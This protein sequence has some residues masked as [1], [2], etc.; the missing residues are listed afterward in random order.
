MVTDLDGLGQQ[1]NFQKIGQNPDFL[2]SNDVNTLNIPSYEQ[3]FEQSL[4]EDP[5]LKIVLTQF[6]EEI[7]SLLKMRYTE[8]Y[9]SPVGESIEAAPVPVV[10]RMVEPVVAVRVEDKPKTYSTSEIRRTL[11]YLFDKVK[12]KPTGKG[13]PGAEK[14]LAKPTPDEI[15][16][17][18]N[19]GTDFDAPKWFVGRIRE[20]RQAFDDAFMRRYHLNHADSIKAVNPILKVLSNSTYTPEQ[21]YA[22]CETYI[23][24]AHESDQEQLQERLQ[25]KFPSIAKEPEQRPITPVL[26]ILRRSPFHIKFDPHMIRATSVLNRV[27]PNVCETELIRLYFINRHIDAWRDGIGKGTQRKNYVTYDE[28]RSFIKEA[29]FYTK[30]SFNRWLHAG[31][32][33]GYWTLASDEKR[34]HYIAFK[35]MPKL[36]MSRLPDELLPD[37]KENQAMGGRMVWADVRGTVQ[38]F[39]GQALGAWIA[40]HERHDGAGVIIKNKNVAAMWHVSIRTVQNWRARVA[41]PADANF[42]KTDNPELPIKQLP[43]TYYPPDDAIKHSHIGK[44]RKVRQMTNLEL[45]SRGVSPGSFVDARK[46]KLHKLFFRSVKELD[47]FVEYHRKRGLNISDRFARI[48]RRNHVAIWERSA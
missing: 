41:I 10:S 45:S 48:Y 18:L 8:R 24:Y 26:S 39:R 22:Y 34:L 44:S 37:F 23:K 17:F 12:D 38:Q 11:Q 40:Q 19:D 7:H 33:A 15:I 47:K 30:S 27:D 2:D 36:L 9:F 13:N 6:P 20:Y 4:I 29:G 35:K 28:L 14:F 21:K 31:A 42:E 32:E 1:N 25:A 3:F 46:A 43:N 16:A 5:K